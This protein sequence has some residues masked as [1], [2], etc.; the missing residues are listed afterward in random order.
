MRSEFTVLARLPLFLAREFSE[1]A[2]KFR[3]SALRFVRLAVDLHPAGE[4]VRSFSAR[5][6]SSIS[7]SSSPESAGV[8]SGCWAVWLSAERCWLITDCSSWAPVRSR[9]LFTDRSGG[10]STG[11]WGAPTGCTGASLWLADESSFLVV[12]GCWLDPFCS[13]ICALTRASA[14]TRSF[15]CVSRSSRMWLSF[16]W[17]GTFRCS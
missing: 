3:F 11:L 5:I 4:L 12:A 10:V 14:C 9:E 17:T 13:S 16:D 6:V 7:F 2:G 15:L 8:S 1:L